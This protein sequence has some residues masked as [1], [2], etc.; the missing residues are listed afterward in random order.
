MAISL[1]P[2]GRKIQGP[3][4]FTLSNIFASAGDFVPSVVVLI[5]VAVLYFGVVFWAGQLET[6]VQNI[7]VQKT[8][9][10]ALSRADDVEKL[11]SFARKVRA[12]NQIVR[13]HNMPSKLF[14]SFEKSIHGNVIITS[15]S[16]N[17]ASGKLDVAGITPS[18]ETLGEQVVIWRNSTTYADSVVLGGFNR[19]SEGQ[20]NF[21][22]TLN[23]KDEFLRNKQ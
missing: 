19:S 5:A 6:E 1:I 17:V 12:L 10:L 14:D 16:L 3:G 9:I 18:F 7:E 2:S 20:V 8:E 4:K 11:K 22:A 23:I 21:S 15:F 13:D